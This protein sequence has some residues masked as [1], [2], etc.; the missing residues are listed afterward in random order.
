MYLTK[1]SMKADF[2]AGGGISDSVSLGSVFVKKE[3]AYRGDKVT[4]LTTLR[5]ETK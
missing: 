2:G 5:T 3:V 1:K 4:P